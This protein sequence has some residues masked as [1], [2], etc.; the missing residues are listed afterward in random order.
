VTTVLS[1]YEALVAAGE[2][3]LDADQRATVIRLDGLAAELAA[4]PARGSILWRML[5]KAPEPPRGIYMWASAAE[6]PC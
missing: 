3:R 2:L 1:R 4:V 6:S 5:R